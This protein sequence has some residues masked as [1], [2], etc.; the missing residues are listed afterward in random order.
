MCSHYHQGARLE[1]VPP[2]K[3]LFPPASFPTAILFVQM[4][5]EGYIFFLCKLAG[6]RVDHVDPDADSVVQQ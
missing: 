1:A 5:H 4:C 2:D 6:P 3:A